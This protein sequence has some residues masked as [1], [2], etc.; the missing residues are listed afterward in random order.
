[1]FQQTM[2][3]CLD[4]TSMPLRDETRFYHE[5]IIFFIWHLLI[6]HINK[7]FVPMAAASAIQASWPDPKCDWETSQGLCWSLGLSCSERKHFSKHFGFPNIGGFTPQNG[8]IYNQLFHYFHHP[9]WGFP[10]IFGNIPH[11]ARGKSSPLDCV[12]HL[13]HICCFIAS[14]HCRRA[15]LWCGGH[16]RD[17]QLC[18]A[19]TRCFS[20]RFRE[21]LS[22]FGDVE[23]GFLFRKK[24][25]KK[26]A[27]FGHWNQ[28]VDLA[29]LDDEGRKRSAA[30][31]NT[32]PGWS[33]T[34]GL[35]FNEK[36]CGDAIVI[37]LE[38]CHCR[39][40]ISTCRFA[41]SETH[42]WMTQMMD[43]Q[44]THLHGSWPGFWTLLIIF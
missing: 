30:V 38:E 18:W 42:P 7:V 36:S 40:G 22:F 16:Y 3:I 31:N 27:W 17:S 6:L 4:W 28:G 10:T 39:F 11:F 21:G 5:I 2:F 20:C 33:G 44:F 14:I 1:M 8:S 41:G 35:K 23:S 15:C 19:E 25:E 24:H 34:P 13:L 43:F 9:F 12:A 26:T 37:Q 32:Y 29:L